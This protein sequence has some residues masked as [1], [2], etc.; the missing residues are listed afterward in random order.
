MDGL[1]M[2]I[3]S[4]LAVACLAWF[5]AQH[6]AINAREAHVHRMRLWQR[7]LDAMERDWRD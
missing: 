1:L 3:L 7:R 4:L 5:Y 6:L 2:I